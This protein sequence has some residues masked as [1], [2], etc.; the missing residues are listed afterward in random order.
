LVLYLADRDLRLVAGEGDAGDCLLFHDLVLFA[1]EGSGR[2]LVR[3]DVLGAVE[4]RAHE[5]AHVMH[6]AELHRAHLHHFGAERSEL[7]HFL[8]RDLVEPPRPRHHARIGGVDA[9]N[10]RVDVAAVGADRGRD[11]DSRRI[12][13]AAAERGDALRLLV[14][15]LEAGDDR[16]LLA[17]FEALDQFGAVD[18]DDAR[19]GMRVRGQ[20]RQLPAQPGSG[21]DIRVLQHDGEQAGRHLFAGGDHSV[22]FPRVENVT[23]LQRLFAPGDKLI[24]GA[25]H[26]R[27]YDGDLM[28]GV[29]LALDVARH[30]ADAVD[31]GDRR[32]A[33]FH[34]QTGHSFGSQ[35]ITIAAPAGPARNGAYTYRRGQG[36]ATRTRLL[37]RGPGRLGLFGL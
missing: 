33:E 2:I 25:R 29:D 3:V 27:D 9:I 14:Q 35:P 6:H 15:A 7:Q 24:G 32:S 4:T 19:G 23:L 11:R 8:E 37:A 17:L 16:D 18:V 10:V 28:A 36:A 12:R 20:D 31:I 5:D 26:G 1:D 34:H 21:V 22:I 30:V 13:T